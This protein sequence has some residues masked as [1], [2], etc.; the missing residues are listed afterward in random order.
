L[1]PSKTQLQLF[2]HGTIIGGSWSSLNK[3]LATVLG[4]DE[5]AKPVQIIKNSVKDIKHKTFSA[6]EFSLG[7]DSTTLFKSMKGPKWEFHYKNIIP[8]PH[9]LTKTF[10]GLQSFNP[11]SVA[12]A[13][14]EAIY[15][16]DK[17]TQGFSDLRIPVSTDPKSDQKE[18]KDLDDTLVKQNEDDLAA[19]EKDVDALFLPT[20]S[21]KEFIHIIQFCHLYM[22]GIIPPVLHI[23]STLNDIKD[24]FT[25]ISPSGYTRQKIAHS[26]SFDLSIM[27]NSNREDIPSSD[28]KKY[29]KERPLHH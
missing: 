25:S 16:F 2:H 18:D 28:K 26:R 10:I 3:L 13:L 1:D 27:S 9:F 23:L 20:S 6:Q 4:F 15:G 8:I 17:S 5:F 29:V 21:M 7:L 14:F 12:K 11:Y 22:K 19:D 24:Q